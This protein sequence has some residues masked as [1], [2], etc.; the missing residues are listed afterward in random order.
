MSKGTILVVAVAAVL[1][2]VAAAAVRIEQLEAGHARQVEIARAEGRREI[3][4]YV[5]DGQVVTGPLEIPPHVSEL[6]NVLVVYQPPQVVLD[7]AIS[8]KNTTNL[9][10]S[11]VD[12]EARGTAIFGVNI[13]EGNENLTVSHCTFTFSGEWENSLG[14]K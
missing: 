9:F 11:H 12:V 5:L 4:S 1:S 13:M 2:V 6:T 14:D 7:S 8:I 10:M 3:L